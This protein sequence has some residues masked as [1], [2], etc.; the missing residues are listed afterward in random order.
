MKSLKRKLSQIKNHWF[1]SFFSIFGMVLL[2]IIIFNFFPKIKEEERLN[3]FIISEI[4]SPDFKN[5]FNKMIDDDIKEVVVTSSSLSDYNLEYVFSTKGLLSSDLF[6]LPK[7]YVIETNISSFFLEIESNTYA[8]YLVED[9]IKYGILLPLDNDYYLNDYIGFYD[10]DYYLLINA[11]TKFVNNKEMLY[12]IIDCII[13][14]NN[15]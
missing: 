15:E 5:E 8:D 9:G 11:N 13:G 7:S 10:E 14:D 2:L 4:V 6:I 1:I 12:S 3:I